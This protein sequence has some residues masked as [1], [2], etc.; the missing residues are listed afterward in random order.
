MTITDQPQLN[1]QHKFAVIVPAAGVGKRMKTLQPKQYLTIDNQTVLEHTVERLLTHPAIDKVIIAIGSEDEYYATTQLIQ[2]KNVSTVVGGKERVDS[3]L[4]GLKAININEYPWVLVHDAARPCVS[5][6]D[7]SALISQCIQLN[8]GGLLATPIRDTIK[9]SNNNNLVRETVDREQLWHALTPQLYP[10]SIL[11]QAIETA[12][13]NNISITDEASA[14]EYLGQESLL[15]EGSGDNI[16]ITRPDDLH[17][18]EF[19]LA[20]QN[21][22]THTSYHIKEEK[23]E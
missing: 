3:V 19:I 22:V 18:A 17:L 23:C 10:T 7:I 12:L 4:A 21:N 13:A 11:L 16:K 6:N 15:V 9:R 5:H 1:S 2:L 14:I 8:N 20:K